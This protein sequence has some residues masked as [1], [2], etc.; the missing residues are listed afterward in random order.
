MGEE[1]SVNVPD[2]CTACGARVLSGDLLRHTCAPSANQLPT[3]ALR[4]LPHEPACAALLGSW[5]APCDCA[6]QE[7]INRLKALLAELQGG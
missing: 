2:V 1:V 5:S 7:L 4:F 6:K 3:R